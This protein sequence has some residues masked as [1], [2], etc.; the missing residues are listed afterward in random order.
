MLIIWNASLETDNVEKED[1]IGLL[2]YDEMVA[3]YVASLY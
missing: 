2:T 1:D 3:R